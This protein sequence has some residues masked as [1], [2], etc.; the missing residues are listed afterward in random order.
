MRLLE[1][2]TEVTL[3]RLLEKRTEVENE[4]AKMRKYLTKFSLTELLNS[5]RTVFSLD[6]KCAKV[7][8]YCRSRQE[9]SNEYLHAK[10]GFDRAENEPLKVSQ[11]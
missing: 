5:E 2:R 11:K 7:C 3:M 6:S 8:K 1:K 4:I 9:L 10:F